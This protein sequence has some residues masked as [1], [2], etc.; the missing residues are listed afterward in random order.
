MQC[1]AHRMH[2][3]RFN[4]TLEDDLAA[5][6]GEAS[7]RDGLGDVARRNRAVE[8]TGVAGRA[9]GNEDLAIEPLGNGF[10]FL[11]QLEVVGFELGAL[12]IE[13]LAVLFRRAQRLLLRQKEI[14]GIAVLH[15][16]DV[17]HLSKTANAL[18][19]NNLHFKCSLFFLF[20]CLMHASWEG[21]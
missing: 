21:S 4:R 1:N 12:R 7:R 9:D 10:G 5:V 11:L 6:D 2:A 18:K 20:V 16:D 19:Q 3:Q 8:L 14:A 13:V 15:V 17:A